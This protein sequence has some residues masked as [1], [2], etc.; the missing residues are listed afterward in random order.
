MSSLFL[1]VTVAPTGTV[2]VCGPK[3]KLSIFISAV[4]AEGRSFAVTFGDPATSSTIAMIT[5]AV[6][7]ATQMRFIVLFPL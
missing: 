7:L 6:K 4:A 1:H 5:A 3:M 2:I